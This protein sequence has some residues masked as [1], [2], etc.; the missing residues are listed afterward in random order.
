MVEQQS[1][2]SDL[3]AC[4]AGVLWGEAIDFLV[5]RGVSREDAGAF[6]DKV[7]WELEGLLDHVK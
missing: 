3:V 4:L 6:A 5:T 7:R 2:N 1:V